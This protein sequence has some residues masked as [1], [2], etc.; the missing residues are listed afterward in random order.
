MYE[1]RDVLAD[2]LLIRPLD[3]DVYYY[4]RPGQVESLSKNTYPLYPASPR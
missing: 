4:A 2:D 3:T 1:G